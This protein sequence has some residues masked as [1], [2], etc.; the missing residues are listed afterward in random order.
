[1]VLPGED[2]ARGSPSSAPTCLPLD[3][4]CL[5]EDDDEND[6]DDDENNPEGEEICVKAAR[7]CISQEKIGGACPYLAPVPENVAS[8]RQYSES[9]HTLPPPPSPGPTRPPPLASEGKP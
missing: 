3:I 7:R 5:R 8:C 9:E 4:A 6:D 1:M 2:E